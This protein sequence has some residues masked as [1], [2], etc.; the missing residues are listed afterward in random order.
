MEMKTTSRPPRVVLAGNILLDVVKQIDVW[1][2][3]GHLASIVGQQ[4]ACGG[5]VCNSGVFLKTLDPSFEVC[6]CGK[7]GMD[8]YGDWLRAFLEGKRLDVMRAA[9]TPSSRRTTSTWTRSAAISFTSAIFFCWTGSTRPTPN[10]ER[11]PRGCCTT[12]RRAASA[13]AL[14]S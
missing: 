1:P 3:Q 10:T 11:W 13:R 14:T 7:V 4:R 2:E 12:S 8:E 5:A 9:Q 6:A